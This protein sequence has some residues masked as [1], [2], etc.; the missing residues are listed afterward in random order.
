MK[1]KKLLFFYSIIGL[2]LSL[3]TACKNHVTSA[4]I[5]ELLDKQY[6]FSSS[7]NTYAVTYQYTGLNPYQ[8]H[9][10]KHPEHKIN[11]YGTYT[12]ELDKNKQEYFT[13]DRSQFP[14]NY[15][16]EFKHFKHQD[17]AISYD[18]NK[19]IRGNALRTLGANA[20]EVQAKRT[21]NVLD[22]EQVAS[23]LKYHK[24]DKPITV[25]INKD[26]NEAVITVVVS[27]KITNTYTFNTNSLSLTRLESTEDNSIV[28]FKNNVILNKV[29][30]AKNLQVFKSDKLSANIIIK[31]VVKTNGI[32][33]EKYNIPKEYAL[34][35]SIDNVAPMVRNIAKNIFLINVANN[36]RF[37]VC[38]VVDKHL[39]VFGAPRS[40]EISK[41]VIQ[42]LS[43]K[44]PNKTIKS[45]FVSHPHSDHISGLRAYAKLGATILADDYTKQAILD[46][47]DFEKEATN[48]KFEVI[49]HK[50]KLDGVRYYVLKNDHSLKQ[51]FAY[52]EKA[53]LIYEG[54]FLEIPADNTIATH[55]SNVEKQF[56]EF[57][58]KENLV[59]RRVVQHHRNPNVSMATINAYYQD[60]TLNTSN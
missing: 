36:S 30:Y 12:I 38:K 60:N 5:F 4:N 26:K 18:V 46:F 14:G 17:K 25:I 22:F 29:P 2:S 28:N 3:I 27:D 58:K 57:I 52:F 50:K 42:L 16:F 24:E 49:S 10:Y 45:V 32:A 7:L 41:Q 47:P 43:N 56:I 44:F 53:Q 48:F 9:D 15:I 6:A 23:L 59:I 39:V 33:K 21:E 31:K 19:V 8:S 40:D 13:H 11:G 51:S 35:K 20:Y 55:L 34:P 1:H 37:I 54:D